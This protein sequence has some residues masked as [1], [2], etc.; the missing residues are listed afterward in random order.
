V[1]HFAHGDAEGCLALLLSLPALDLGKGWLDGV[2]PQQLAREAGRES[3]AAAIEQEVR[4][5]SALRMPTTLHTPRTTLRL[6]RLL[7]HTHTL[8]RTPIPS[9]LLTVSVETTLVPAADRVGGC[10]GAGSGPLDTVHQSRLPLATPPF[11]LTT[12]GQIWFRAPSWPRLR[13]F[14]AA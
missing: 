13:R 8:S 7:T 12:Q 5:P 9:P 3:M 1:V 4:L 11:P 14:P 6:L 2:P 10:S